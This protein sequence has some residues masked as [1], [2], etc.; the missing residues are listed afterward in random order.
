PPVK[1]G[2]LRCGSR[3]GLRTT[4]AKQEPANGSVYGTVVALKTLLARGEGTAAGEQRL[5]SAKTP[6][7][8]WAVL[9]IVKCL[10]IGSAAG[11]LSTVRCDRLV[12]GNVARG[13][14]LSS[15]LQM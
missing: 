11:F 3:R 8:D 15:R 6:S 9:S 1:P 14:G 10:G 4:V 12:A 5:A 13:T 2:L 7:F